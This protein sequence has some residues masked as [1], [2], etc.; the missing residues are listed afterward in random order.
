[1]Q[2]VAKMNV[3]RRITTR[4]STGTKVETQGGG[5]GGK[6]QER[7]VKDGETLLLC[8]GN[9]APDSDKKEVQEHEVLKLRASSPGRPLK[10][11]Q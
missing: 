5:G 11:P 8:L 3:G 9:T 4:G 10:G 1:M 2:L 6:A 7:R